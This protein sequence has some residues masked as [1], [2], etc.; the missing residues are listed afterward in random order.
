MKTFEVTLKGF[1]GSTD[2]TDHLVK[3]VLASSKEKVEEAFKGIELHESVKELVDFN[4]PM[5]DIDFIIN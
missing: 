1:D 4:P 2:Q 3:W 5:E